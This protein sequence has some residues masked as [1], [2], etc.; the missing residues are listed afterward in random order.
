MPN[1]RAILKV[2]WKSQTFWK[3]VLPPAKV[4]TLQF[5]HLLPAPLPHWPQV[6]LS[7]WVGQAGERR[8]HSI[9]H[10]AEWKGEGKAGLAKRE[11][12]LTQR[13]LRMLERDKDVGPDSNPIEADGN[14]SMG[15]GSGLCSEMKWGNNE[16]L[17]RQTNWE[18][19]EEDGMSA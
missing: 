12:K 16:R 19:E 14:I 10:I 3:V 5:L 13:Q 8:F 15:L 2:N 11:E 7:A 9:F 17:W 4:C 18:G 6:S 1:I